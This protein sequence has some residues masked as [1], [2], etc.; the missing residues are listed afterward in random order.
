VRDFIIMHYKLT[1]RDDSDFWR[2]CAAMPIPDSLQHQIELF[3]E[4]GRVAVLDPDGFTEPSFVSM[5]M[6][7]GI[8]PQSYDPF[9][10]MVDVEHL[11]K[12]FVH[13]RNAVASTAHA[14]PDHTDYIAQYVKA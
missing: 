9:V 8:V 1:R 14:M 11:H 6:G 13:V 4:S 3:R 7:L 12:H 2:H 10:D 5:F